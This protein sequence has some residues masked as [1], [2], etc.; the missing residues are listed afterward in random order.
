MSQEQS[1]AGGGLEN[2]S[3]AYSS[4]QF[5]DNYPI[6]ME[7][8]YWIDAR[9][10]ILRR[11]IQHFFTPS[12]VILDVGCGTGV[13]VDYLTK[14]GIPCYGVELGCPTI[15]C[16]S[17]ERIHTGCSVRDLPDEFRKSIT[18]VLL[19]DVLEH[20]NNPDDLLSEIRASLPNVKKAIVT[21]PARKELWSNYDEHFGHY[22]R[23][24]RSQLQGLIE[25][26]GGTV[27]SMRYFFHGLYLPM[28]LVSKLGLQRTTTNTTPTR[29]GIHR[30][31]ASLF[32]L[33][34]RIL[35]GRILGASLI[36]HVMWLDSPLRTR[37]GETTVGSL[38]SPNNRD[39]V[40]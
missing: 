24:S 20:L 10:R 3:S 39:R 12:D 37:V 13:V 6:G 1:A 28:L 9:N 15:T 4:E 11:H 27:A 17:K 25:A 36:A 14:Q 32:A 2:V 34:E 38:S 29:L 35:S 23:Y 5:G 33:E 16:T 22:L 30:G 40:D 7:N 19:L 21:V 31:I 18:S 26:N 8:H